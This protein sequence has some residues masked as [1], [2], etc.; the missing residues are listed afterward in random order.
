MRFISS[1]PIE[2]GFNSNSLY[3]KKALE[4]GESLESLIKAEAHPMP[5]FYM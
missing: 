3:G 2:N 5:S 1:C 4:S